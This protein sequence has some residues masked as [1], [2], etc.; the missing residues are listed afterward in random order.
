MGR[1]YAVK[2]GIQTGI[3][4]S[5][6]DCEQHT[7][8]YAGALF[9]RF[10]TRE[11]AQAYLDDREP[12]RD[13]VDQTI[14]EESAKSKYAKSKNVNPEPE[15]IIDSEKV[16]N[17]IDNPIMKAR[18]SQFVFVDGSHKKK[19]D[20]ING[21]IN[22]G[23]YGIYFRDGFPHNISS[24]VDNPTNNICELLAILNV[25]KI[26]K[27]DLDKIKRKINYIIVSDSKY[28]I[29]CLT[30]WYKSWMRNGWRTTGNKPVK[31]LEII[32]QN[33]DLLQ[34]FEQCE[35]LDIYFYHQR[36]HQYPPKNKKSFEYFLWRGNDMA[37]KF[38]KGEIKPT[39]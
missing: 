15:T 14:K 30:V 13:L 29:Q 11:E 25:L 4:R 20:P 31:N 8:G 16:I 12:D 2:R 19:K 18:N 34:Q 22:C 7:K 26:F 37:D 5:W 35:N 21:D 38:A 6:K 3:F 28:C 1:Y 24:R 9:K 10:S 36:S 33:L 23:G 39:Y 17:S 32:Q 27:R